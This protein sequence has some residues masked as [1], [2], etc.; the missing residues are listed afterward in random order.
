MHT[1]GSLLANAFPI[2]YYPSKPAWALFGTTFEQVLY[3]LF[4]AAAAD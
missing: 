1:R 2:L 4:F 3:H